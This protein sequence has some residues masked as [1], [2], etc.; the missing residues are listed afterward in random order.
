MTFG[1][2]PLLKNTEKDVQGDFLLTWNMH[3]IHFAGIPP[4]TP[5]GE[6]MTPP[7]NLVKWWGDIPPHVSSL[8]TP[9]A[10]RSRRIRNEAV[11]GPC[12]NGF[13]GPAVALDGPVCDQHTYLVNYT[14]AQQ[15]TS[16]AYISQKEKT[17][18]TTIKD[19]QQ[20]I[21]HFY[22]MINISA[23]IHH[24]QKGWYNPS[25]GPISLATC[26]FRGLT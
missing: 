9:S 14:T 26:H 11:I 24:L 2:P 23:L 22:H 25:K 17:Q 18:T 12:N 19:Y 3:K 6:L 20:T 8:S 1:G 15:H 13:L 16:A 10:S 21:T 7:R 4:R 5:L